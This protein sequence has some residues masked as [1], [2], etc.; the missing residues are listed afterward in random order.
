MNRR[1]REKKTENFLRAPGFEPT[2]LGDAIHQRMQIEPPSYCSFKV[3]IKTLTLLLATMK[4]FSFPLAAP[5]VKLTH[6]FHTLNI[7]LIYFISL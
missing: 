2:T 5:G 1:G 4:M 6:F 3:A 7:L